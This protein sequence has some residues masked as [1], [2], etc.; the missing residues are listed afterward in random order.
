[1]VEYILMGKKLDL[2]NSETIFQT[3]FKDLDNWRKIGD[4]NWEISCNSLI[5]GKIGETTH[6]QILYGEKFPGDVVMEF[7]AQTVMPSDHDIIWWW[8]TEIKK[9]SWGKGYL[10]ALAG[11]WRNKTGIEKSPDFKL[12]ATTPLFDFVPGKKHHIV[13]GSINGHC[14]IF[15]DGKLIIEVN[16]PAPLPREHA[17]H[18]GF[19]VF[20]SCVKYENLRIYSPKWE[21]FSEEYTLD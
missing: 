20:Q 7:D 8:R 17:G 5:G 16:D 19:G 10:G 1:M 13:S 11:W 3:D 14:F 2:A 6:G 9:D 21:K 12:S 4:V 15:A 18:V